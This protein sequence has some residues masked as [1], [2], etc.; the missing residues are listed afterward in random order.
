MDDV[1]GASLDP[2]KV[3][4]A[5][6]EEMKFFRS[7]NAYTRC[8]RSAVEEEGGIISTCAGFTTI[9]ETRTARTTARG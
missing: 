1:T 6:G 8:P 2:G 3:R 7:R 4:E 5:R 9:K